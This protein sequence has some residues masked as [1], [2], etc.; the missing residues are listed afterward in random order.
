M[1]II[2]AGAGIGGLTAALSLHQI[3]ARVRVYETA[4]AIRPLG[5]GI[6][7]LPHAI[8]ELFDLGLEE[9]LTAQGM[10]T[11]ALAYYSKRGQQIWKEPRGKLAGYRWPQISIHRGILQHI[12]C[13]AV[14]ERLGPDAIVTD[15]TLESWEDTGASV[16]CIFQRKAGGSKVEV[17][18]L[19]LIG[20]DGIHSTVRKQLYPDEGH[21]KWGGAILWRGV[22]ANS[23]YLDGRTMIMAGHEFQKFVCYPIAPRDAAEPVVNWIAELKYAPGKV[24]NREDWNRPGKLEDFLPQFQSWSFDWLDV[25]KLIQGAEG[26]HEYPMV[27]RDPL[28]KWTFG[29]ATLLGDAAHAMYPIG[30]NGASQAILDARVLA[31]EIRERGA[32]AAALDAYEGERRAATTPIILANRKNGPEQVM[33]LV[34]ERAPQGYAAVSDVLKQEEL[35]GVA[36]AYKRI[37]G[38]SIEELNAKPGILS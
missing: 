7:V 15:H 2:I 21:P 22:T 5:V 16:H 17:D 37:A 20:A 8:R 36:S 24:F 31:R 25:P 14:M 32:T 12:L 6:N 35:E 1:T 33:Q 30:S 27:D 9:R 34:E 28:P 18:G 19:M 29:R 11:A 10:P 23:T 3:G 13:D 4:P 26:C 38:F